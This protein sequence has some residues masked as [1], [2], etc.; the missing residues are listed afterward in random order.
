MIK[1]RRETLRLA[2]ALLPLLG[3]GSHRSTWAATPDAAA[4]SPGAEVARSGQP[5]P[6]ELERRA[7][8]RLGV[9]LLDTATGTLTGHRL[10][11]R[12]ALCSTFKLLLAAAV[13]QQVDAGR[14]SLTQWVPLR[15][16]DRVP[17]APVAGPAIARGGAPL[18]EL[19]RAIQTTSDNVAANVLMRL[20]GGPA[21]LTTWLRAQGDAH[22]R[23]DRWEPEMNRVGPGD[24][25][26]TTTPAAMARSTARLVLGEVLCPRSRERLQG[27][28][29][30]TETGLKRLRA[31][32]PA[33]WR[34]GDKTG[35]A[36]HPDFPD[37]LNDVAVLWPPAGRAPLVVAAYYQGP[38]RS[39]QGI[40]DEDQAV[41]AGVG[42]WAV[43]SGA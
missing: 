33:G 30:E 10:D 14:L 27:W 23:L 15:A 3:L 18:G 34:A 29:V 16:A 38:G 11:E 25:R 5:S 43:R 4:A 1:H 22:T 40:R 12:F 9:A 41:L 17:H 35:T 24:E 42:R 26:D 19:T 2:L 31:D 7:G 28:M 6:A 32:L 37:Q 21:A 36:L 13:L 39:A 8:G 20:L